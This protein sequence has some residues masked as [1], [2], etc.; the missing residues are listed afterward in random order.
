MEH[1][2]LGKFFSKC[3]HCNVKL[4]FMSTFVK[5]VNFF[6][7]KERASYCGRAP[8]L[9]D[10]MYFVLNKYEFAARRL[11]LKISYTKRVKCEMNGSDNDSDANTLR[12]G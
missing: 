3:K 5:K 2:I 4:D 12:V 10:G 11:R 8:R 9:T 7:G 1:C 6:F